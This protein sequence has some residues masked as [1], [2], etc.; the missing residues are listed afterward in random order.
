V[1]DD[2]DLRQYVQVVTRRWLWVVGA[3]VVAAVVA[4]VVSSLLPPTYEA[5]AL[6]A[7]TEPRY[8][9]VFVSGFETLQDVEVPSQAF[10]ELATSD[11]LL[12]DL[13]AELEPRPEGIETI[14]DLRQVLAARLGSDPSV[15]RLIVRQGEPEVAAVIANAWADLFVT[16]ANQIYGTQ[17]AEEVT[18]LEAQLEQAGTD[19]ETAEE[20]L[21]AFQAR[22]EAAIVEA[23][24]ASAQQDLR[25]YLTEQRE[26]E[27]LVRNVLALQ[28]RVAGQ[29]EGEQVGP[30]DAVTALLLQVQAFSARASQPARSEREGEFVAE[31]PEMLSVDVRLVET[32]QA[33]PDLV[34]QIQVGDPALFAGQRT[35][36]ELA[37]SLTDLLSTLRG[38]QSEI[39]EHA[40]S[41]EPHILT[42]QEELQQARME[43]YRLATA[44]TAARD[45][46]MTLTYKLQEAHVRATSAGG[47]VRLASRASVPES[48]AGPRRVFNTLVAGA[49]SLILSVFGVFVYE[50]WWGSEAARPRARA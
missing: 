7:M 38:W 46:Y 33:G 4:F 32:T 21:T 22:N 48:P 43:E 28:T 1:E 30:D 12:E 35:A 3:T 13:L 39:T 29:A 5:R 2:I 23:R 37:G 15:V 18:F 47:G 16:R 31:V 42:L 34:V 45:T 20:A 41:L 40:A 36:G 19:L 50:W 24:L 25:D 10:P 17:G 6:A 49:M 26:I 11:A 44:V 14:E 8:A 27:R 9:L